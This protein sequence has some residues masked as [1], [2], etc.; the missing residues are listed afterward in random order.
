MKITI[1]LMKIFLKIFYERHFFSFFFS[2]VNCIL[3]GNFLIEFDK[4]I[5]LNKFK[6]LEYSIERK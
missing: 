3:N 5:E 6:N 4:K 2:L 1:I